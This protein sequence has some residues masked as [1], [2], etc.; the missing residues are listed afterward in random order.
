MKHTIEKAQEYR[1]SHPNLF[2]IKCG[3]DTSYE[4]HCGNQLL[5]L[6][7]V[8]RAQTY[9]QIADSTTI[10]TGKKKLKS[11]IIR[12]I[13]NEMKEQCASRFLRYDKINLC[14]NEIPKQLAHEKVSHSMR[15]YIIK[16]GIAAGIDKAPLCSKNCLE[17]N[18]APS[19]YSGSNI[20]HSIFEMDPKGY[21]E[22]SMG[23]ED[24]R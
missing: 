5:R 23:Y 19:G 8:S 12:Q 22:I 18:I 2:D 13:V 9:H 17:H 14:W 10:T 21:S 6:K 1:T 24:Y 20:S 7:I 4:N 15:T 3:Q 11:M 16:S